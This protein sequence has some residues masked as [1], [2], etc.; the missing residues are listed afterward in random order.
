MMK[1]ITC[2]QDLLIEDKNL[3]AAL[4]I[5]G[6]KVW[7]PYNHCAED[8]VQAAAELPEEQQSVAAS[9]AADPTRSRINKWEEEHRLL[10][11]EG[12]VEYLPAG[13]Q[14]YTRRQGATDDLFYA[15]YGDVVKERGIITQLC[16]RFHFGRE[17]AGLSFFEGAEDAGEVEL[18]RSI[19]R[20]EIPKISGDDDAICELRGQAQK[21]D[22][23]QFW[24][25]IEE[26]EAR[27][28]GSGENYVRRAEKIQMDF[29]KWAG[30]RWVFRGKSLATGGLIL[31]CLYNSN[32]WPLASLAGCSWIG[33]LN[34]A[35]AQRHDPKRK[36]FKFM[37]RLHGKIKKLAAK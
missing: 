8:F 25:M 11:K 13:G 10:F 20:L 29:E 1:E 24:Q 16:L 12:I 23:K 6:G 34:K 33:D 32:F 27:A 4:C 7:L 37:A 30:D 26:L 21:R 19:F 3:L 28:T 17:T 5:F 2:S 9:L 35:W 18:A 14:A 31:L 22:I 36:A 15:A